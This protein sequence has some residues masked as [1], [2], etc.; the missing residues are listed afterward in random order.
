MN[1]L[2]NR[3]L[4]PGIRNK[5]I[6]LIV[7]IAATATTIFGVYSFYAPK[8]KAERI[9]AEAERAVQQG[10]LKEAE[11]KLEELMK[12][13]PGNA[14]V[15]DEL[16]RVKGLIAG[17]ASG[18]TGTSGNGSGSG[19]GGSQTGGQS[20]SQN[21]GGSTGSDGDG[22]GGSGSGNPGNG[23]GGSTGGDS[24]TNSNITLQAALPQSITGYTLLTKNPGP[25]EESR[26]YKPDKAG[27]VTLLTVVARN[28]GDGESA[29]RYIDSL[30]SKYSRDAKDLTVKRR[31]AYFGTDG[32]GVAIILWKIS[33]I[34]VGVEAQTAGPE[35][36]SLISE[37]SAV[38]EQFP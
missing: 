17:G 24:G 4:E 26:T 19:S 34:V 10:E 2:L 14:K 1:R 28:E 27:T 31:P 23:S 38:A 6:I 30:K 25:I 5:I 9:F 3:L 29:Q 35:A 33:N 15:K 11:I 22:S 8:Q 16:A 13:Q 12:E 21:S 20:G 37:L 7:A 32:S 18:S 36:S